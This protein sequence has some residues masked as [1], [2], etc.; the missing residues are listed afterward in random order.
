MRFI[1]SSLLLLASQMAWSQN[2]ESFGIFGGLNVPFTIDQGLY[3][4]SR[5]AAKG[6]VRGTHIGLYYGYVKIGYGLALTPSYV[7]LGQTFKIKNTTGGDVGFRY[8]RTNYFTIPI[9][10]KIHI[11][12]LSFFRLSLVAALTPSILI[13]GQEIM[14]HD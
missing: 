12:D 6:V 14:T 2:T 13:S 10:L 3:K 8:V 1:F 5:F 9:A 4:D 11:N 7:A